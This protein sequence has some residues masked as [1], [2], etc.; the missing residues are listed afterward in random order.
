MVT[1][2]RAS[3]AWI[4]GLAFLAAGVAS[5]RAAIPAEINY[6]GVLR[7]AADQPLSG[8]FDMTFLFWS[9][10]AFGDLIMI[11][12]HLIVRSNPVT[13]TNGLFNVR[14][15]SGQIADG[16][17]PGTYTSLA[18]VFRDYSLVFLEVSVGAET[19]SPRTR[20]V[21]A[22]YALNAENLDGKDSSSFLDTSAT[23]QT[24]DGG[25]FIKGIGADAGLQ[26]WG[27]IGVLG[28]TNGA[29]AVG[30]LGLDDGSGSMG[31]LG[32][33][34]AAGGRFTNLISGADAYVAGG[35]GTNPN[36]GIEAYGS[37]DPAAGTGGGGYFEDTVYG[38]SAKLGH[39]NYGIQGFGSTMGGYFIRPGGAGVAHAGTFGYGLVAHGSYDYGGGGGYFQD[40]T[41]G[42]QALVAFGGTGIYG[43]GQDIGGSFND[44][45]SGS[46]GW[47][48]VS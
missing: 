15:G 34:V 7:D 38:S 45:T 1:K 19:L 44:T 40:D 21:S 35:S 13:V 23:N 11:D 46:Y 26:A 9:D 3:V 43:Y 22:A 47:S 48:W 32:L 41:Y 20:I 18:D 27:P 31:V 6:Q 30:Y 28:V 36:W 12:R 5:A 8:N 42:S 4:I 25:L 10:S 29:T 17:G 14:L 39:E 2:N 33:G 24:K 16:A 37:Y